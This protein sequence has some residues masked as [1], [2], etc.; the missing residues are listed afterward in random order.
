[1][2]RT[3]GHAD[4]GLSGFLVQTTFGLVKLSCFEPIVNPSSDSPV[5]DAH[6]LSL[7]DTFAGGENSWQCREERFTLVGTLCCRNQNLLFAAN[8]VVRVG[9]I[10]KQFGRKYHRCLKIFVR[11]FQYRRFLFKQFVSF[12]G[13]FE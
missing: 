6:T 7:G 2:Q 9:G 11:T 4:I 5:A 12:I 1:M 3:N 8:H 13:I 10:Q